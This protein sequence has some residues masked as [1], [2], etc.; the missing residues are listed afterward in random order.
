MDLREPE[1]AVSTNEGA[2]YVGKPSA[3]D[4]MA[5]EPTELRCVLTV[6]VR[7]AHPLRFAA[8]Y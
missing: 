5:P 1:R 2:E 7:A 8:A 3:A 6:A 4:V